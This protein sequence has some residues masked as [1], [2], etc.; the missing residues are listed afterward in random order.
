[1]TARVNWCR[2]SY[3]PSAAFSTWIFTIAT[4][5]LRDSARASKQQANVIELEAVRAEVASGGG[6][7]RTIHISSEKSTEEVY[8]DEK[9]AEVLNITLTAA[10]V[11]VRRAMIDLEKISKKDSVSLSC[12]ISGRFSLSQIFSSQEIWA[13]RLQPQR[14]LQQEDSD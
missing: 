3:E 4:N 10:K 14:R 2:K 8:R 13:Q 12:K 6:L 11:G 9:I 1:M 7:I 5:L